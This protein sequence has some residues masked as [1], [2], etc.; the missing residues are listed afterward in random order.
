MLVDSIHDTQLNQLVKKVE[1]WNKQL[2]QEISLSGRSPERDTQL[3][4]GLNLGSYLKN[5]RGDQ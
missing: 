1:H 2:I 4:D 3:L 5:L